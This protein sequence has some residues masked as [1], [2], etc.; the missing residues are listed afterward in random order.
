MQ[1]SGQYVVTFV[2]DSDLPPEQDFMLFEADGSVFL[3]IKQSRVTPCV[4]EQ[5]WQLFCERF[6]LRHD[7]EWGPTIRQRVGELSQRESLGHLA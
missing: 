2:G 5:A 7:E 6:T 3:A 1:I 4:L